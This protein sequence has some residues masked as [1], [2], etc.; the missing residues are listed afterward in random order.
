MIINNEHRQGHGDPQWLEPLSKLPVILTPCRTKE[1]ATYEKQLLKK[2]LR[3]SEKMFVW[4]NHLH[5][6]VAARPAVIDLCYQTFPVLALLSKIRF[7]LNQWKRLH[8]FDIFFFA[9]KINPKTSIDCFFFHVKKILF[10][11]YVKTKIS[12]SICTS[13]TSNNFSI[14]VKFWVIIKPKKLMHSF[15]IIIFHCRLWK[16][17]NEKYRLCKKN[18]IKDRG[19]TPAICCF[20]CWYCYHCLYYSNCFTLLKE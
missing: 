4:L 1:T 9:V 19:S 17:I 2:S 20:H 13:S 10:F 5:V 15:N 12:S 16:S 18:T 7:H 8:S 3:I 14:I 11:F 6:R